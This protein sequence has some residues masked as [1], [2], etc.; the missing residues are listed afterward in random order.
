MSGNLP[1][2]P[3]RV[4]F[5]DLKH[6]LIEAIDLF[7][8]RFFTFIFCHGLFVLASVFLIGLIP[9]LG[10]LV[11]VIAVSFYIIITLAF[12]AAADKSIRPALPTVISSLKNGIYAVLLIAALSIL[13]YAIVDYISP[14]VEEYMPAP[15]SSSQDIQWWNAIFILSSYYL[16]LYLGGCLWLSQL[17]LLPLCSLIEADIRFGIRIAFRGFLINLPV[18]AALIFGLLIAVFVLLLLLPKFL[19]LLLFVIPYFC[20]VTYVAFRHIFLGQ[21]D[22]E[23]VV[24]RQTIQQTINH[25]A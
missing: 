2:E 18:C 7:R 9:W 21:R 10:E 20:I 11:G 14:H 13:I 16:V 6:W 12:A 1:L 17:F 23:P 24:I 19:F 22:N 25:T 5:S 4:A 8:R 3:R 15:A